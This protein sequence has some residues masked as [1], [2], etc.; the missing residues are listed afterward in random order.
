MAGGKL[1]FSVLTGTRG[2]SVEAVG[3]EYRAEERKIFRGVEATPEKLVA[4]GLLAGAY[5]AVDAE[6]EGGLFGL[7][8]GLRLGVA[9]TEVE[10]RCAISDAEMLW[11]SLLDGPCGRPM[12]F[13]EASC[14]SEARFTGL[15]GADAVL[16][17]RWAG[18]GAAGL[19]GPSGLAFCSSVGAT[20]LRNSPVKPKMLRFLDG[21]SMMSL[22]K[23]SRGGVARGKGIAGWRENK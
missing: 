8:P 23:T 7:S 4:F 11:E 20:E 2:D 17:S 22:V 6:K 13:R 9:K 19:L 16:I 3:R 15:C 10:G 21:G 1:W 12:I 18:A 5:D 14:E